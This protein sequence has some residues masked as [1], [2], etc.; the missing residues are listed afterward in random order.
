MKLAK[1]F[2]ELEEKE[3][4]GVCMEEGLGK[5]LLKNRKLKKWIKAKRIAIRSSATF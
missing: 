2:S 1:M 3:S 5:A 4:C